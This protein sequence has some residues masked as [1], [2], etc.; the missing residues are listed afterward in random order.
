MSGRRPAG[1]EPG[2][3]AAALSQGFGNPS[4]EHWLGNEFVSQV[5]NRKRYVLRIRLTDWEGNEAQ[6][7][8]EHFYLS[9]EDLNYR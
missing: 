2:A 3:D 8:Y 5:T 9:G 6:A 7:L 1:E 4:G